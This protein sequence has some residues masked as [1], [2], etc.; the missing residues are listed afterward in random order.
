M[1]FLIRPCWNSSLVITIGSVSPTHS[2]SII[3]FANLGFSDR[4]EIKPAIAFER[5]GDWTGLALEWC[6]KSFI[7][8]L[9]RYPN[10]WNLAKNHSDLTFRQLPNHIRLLDGTG[11]DIKHHNLI[12]NLSWIQFCMHLQKPLRGSKTC[13]GA[14]IQRY[15]RLNY[16]PF[17]SARPLFR[18]KIRKI[19]IQQKFFQRRRFNWVNGI[20]SALI[21]LFGFRW[22]V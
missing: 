1:I 6:L 14:L 11:L 8:L 10:L 18:E 5:V 12:C 4:H 22:L 9:E 19:S 21:S 16:R 7:S 15:D 2:S 13:S 20:Q 3:H 17:W